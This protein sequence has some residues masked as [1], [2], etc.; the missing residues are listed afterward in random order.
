MFGR[1]PGSRAGRAPWAGRSAR[2]GRPPEARAASGAGPVRNSTIQSAVSVLTRSFRSSVKR[3]ST[4]RQRS[5]ASAAVPSVGPSTSRTHSEAQ[6]NWSTWSRCCTACAVAMSRI[7]PE[8]SPRYRS[9]AT[10]AAAISTARQAH[11]EAPGTAPVRSSSGRA[12][13]VA[14]PSAVPARSRRAPRRLRARSAR[15]QSAVER[16]DSSTHSYSS[17]RR[18]AGWPQ[19][20]SGKGRPARSAGWRGRCRSR[21]RASSARPSGCSSGWLTRHSLSASLCGAVVGGPCARRR[22]LADGRTGWY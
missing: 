9:R 3:R 8:V 15:Y 14:A 6:S 16:A 7:H 5:A 17:V 12:A 4:P 1:V 21:G 10:Q 2:A 20:P 13:P 18:S 19:S 22:G 11:G